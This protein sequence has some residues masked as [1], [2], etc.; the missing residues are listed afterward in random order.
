MIHLKQKNVRYLF[1]KR[2]MCMICWCKPMYTPMG[3][4]QKLN[5][6][7][8]NDLANEQKYRSLIGSLVYLTNIRPNIIDVIS[9][10]SRYMNKPSKFHL[11]AAMRIL[12]MWNKS[13]ILVWDMKLRM[14]LNWLDIQIMIRPVAK[15]TG[16]VHQDIFLDWEIRLYHGFLRNKRRLYNLHVKSNT[17]LSQIKHVKLF[18]A[19]EVIWLKRILKDILCDQ[20]GATTMFCDNIYAIVM[21]KIPFFMLDQ[22]ILS[23]GI[24]LLE[25][26]VKLQ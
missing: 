17:F 26:K 25:I 2:S 20:D 23:W 21:N 4:N 10:F 22:K 14:R 24:I 3:M 13:R 1:L 11:M 9:V 12:S 19:C 8:H 6:D 5:K 16:R 7:V 18:G 15:M